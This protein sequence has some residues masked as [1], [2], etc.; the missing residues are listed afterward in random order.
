PEGL[1]L[2]G[3]SLWVANRASDSISR[4][5]QVTNR[6]VATIKV[7][8]GPL[9]VTVS[10][11][12]VWVAN[13]GDGTVSRIDPTTNGVIT[14]QVDPATFTSVLPS[15]VA[16]SDRSVWLVDSHSNR[17]VEIDTTTAAVTRQ[18]TVPGADS[19]PT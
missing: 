13:N 11:G 15:I 2:A 14:V 9:G 7:G 17:L 16:T 19:D 3:G 6:V 8:A 4:I 12:A 10:G 18:V 5:D 1:A